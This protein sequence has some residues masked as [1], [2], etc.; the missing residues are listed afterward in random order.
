MVNKSTMA[1]VA[2]VLA[3]SFGENDIEL[4]MDMMRK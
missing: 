1:K 2:I 4:K 3:G